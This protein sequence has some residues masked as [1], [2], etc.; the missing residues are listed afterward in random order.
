MHRGEMLG[1]GLIAASALAFCACGEETVAPTTALPRSA[2]LALARADATAPAT[3]VTV[4]T[5]RGDQA[6]TAVIRH[7]DAGTTVFLEL[8]FPAHSILHSGGLTVC[9][10]CTVNVTITLTPGVY[11]FT[12]T[13]STMVFRSSSTPTA[14]FVYG[15]YADHSVRDSTT[16]YATEQAFD[17]ALAIWYQTAPDQWRRGRNSH[18][19]AA[20]RVVSG[21]EGPGAHL[22]AAPK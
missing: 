10:T 3:A 17:D 4:V 8:F 18:H 20:G 21:I 1:T 16:R 5:V 2:L 11:G 22:L 15:T 7:P 13:P 19:E 6:R 14:T 12:L 9:D